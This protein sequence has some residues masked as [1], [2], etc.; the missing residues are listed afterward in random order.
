MAIEDDI[1]FLEGVP[2]LGQLG[3]QALRILAIGADMRHLRAGEVLFRAGEEA[4]GAF[5]IQEGR[6][7][8]APTAAPAVTVGPGTLLGESA[9]FTNTR[10]AA[11]ATALEPASLLRIP[12]PLFLRMLDSFPST[13][14]KLRDIMAL[15]LDQS[16]RELAGVRAKLDAYEPK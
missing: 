2:T 11:T 1:A 4:D 12:R 9:L 3:R 10:R 5:V 14:R 6:I 13:A 16:D 15:R 8:L 7:A